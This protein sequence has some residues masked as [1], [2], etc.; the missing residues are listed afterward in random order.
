MNKT[1]K[2]NIGQ[3][4]YIILYINDLISKSFYLIQLT[5]L[6]YES[7][8]KESLTISSLSLSPTT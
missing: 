3:G 2:K 6:I 8:K 5:S 4:Y 7:L 1:I